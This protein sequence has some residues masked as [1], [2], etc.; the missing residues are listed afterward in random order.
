MDKRI[1]TLS[2]H[3]L[4]SLLFSY[5]WRSCLTIF[6]YL[7]PPRFLHFFHFLFSS[8]SIGRN[9]MWFHAFQSY[10]Y[11]FLFQEVFSREWDWS[12]MK[13]H[14]SLSLL[15]LPHWRNYFTYALDLSSSSLTLWF[16]W[17]SH[18]HFPLLYKNLS[19][20]FISH[21]RK[22]LIVWLEAVSLKGEREMR[23][24]I[25]SLTLL[26]FESSYRAFNKKLV[27]RKEGTALHL[28]H[29]NVSSSSFCSFLL[30]FFFHS[31]SSNITTK[32]ERFL[33]PSS[34]S[35]FA[36]TNTNKWMERGDRRSGWRKKKAWMVMMMWERGEE[37]EKE[38]MR[39][40][41][42]KR[43][44]EKERQ[45]RCWFLLG[46]I[47]PLFLTHTF[48]VHF[49]FS[50]SFISSSLPPSSLHLFLVFVWLLHLWQYLPSFLIHH[51]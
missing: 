31:F 47:L 44:R 27:G 4:F 21:I 45:L 40:R 24:C 43:E 15:L 35:L 17:L 37:R 36:H 33:T 34:R 25:H 19:F 20:P 18:F 7:N 30:F 11:F 32:I 29:S 22:S 39:E 26:S 28:T 41:G 12:G 46:N 23:V 51:S 48:V 8:S 10:Y 2:F 6:S 38:R 5:P 49:Y 42:E 50:S 9:G 14:L 13:A 1:F 3:S 16:Q